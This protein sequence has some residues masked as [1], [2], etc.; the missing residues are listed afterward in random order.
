VLLSVFIANLVIFL[1]F[2][3]TVAVISSFFYI[4]VIFT[5]FQYPLRGIFTSATLGL[6]FLAVIYSLLKMTPVTVTT[7]TV[8]FYVFVAVG[9]LVSRLSEEL[10]EQQIRYQ[11]IFDHSQ[12]GVM[13]VRR[14]N[15]RIL[16]A[17]RRC[18]DLLESS[19]EGLA[20]R[21]LSSIWLDPEERDRFFRRLDDEGTVTDYETRVLAGQASMRWIL[22]SA[23]W[24]SPDLVVCAM[25]DISSRRRSEEEIQRRNRELGLMNRII[26]ASTARE[27][28]DQIFPMAVDAVLDYLECQ[29]GALYLLDPDRRTGELRY[30][31][32]ISPGH[33]GTPSSGCRWKG[34]CSGRPWRA[35]NRSGCTNMRSGGCLPGL[36]RSVPLP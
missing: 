21:P 35:G 31:T 11:G 28:S 14:S 12:A 7:A 15:Q 18:A 4:P 9:T 33:T 5:A 29:A 17:N 32:G 6:V 26:A 2:E 20:G 23:G 8:Q 36:T 16:E 10:R 30:H 13:L 22:V 24:I 34:P 25:V 19:P 1:L 3:G 27:A